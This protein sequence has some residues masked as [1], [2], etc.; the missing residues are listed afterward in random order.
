MEQKLPSTALTKVA[1][2][3]VTSI[4]NNIFIENKH[5]FHKTLSLLKNSWKSPTVR[6]RFYHKLYEK[7]FQTEYSYK[8]FIAC[9]IAQLFTKFKIDNTSL[10]DLFDQVMNPTVDNFIAQVQLFMIDDL[11]INPHNKILME[12][13]QAQFII[14]CTMEINIIISLLDKTEIKHSE[15]QYRRLLELYKYS[16]YT[17][18]P[19]EKQDKSTQTE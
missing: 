9:V 13:L 3:F 16:K 7:Y 17:Q 18:Q 8:E 10:D 11:I 2:F 6:V 12:T 4:C 15:Q 1:E 5:D 14:C 19:V